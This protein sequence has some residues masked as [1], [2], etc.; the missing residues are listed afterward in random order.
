MGPSGSSTKREVGVGVCRGLFVS[1]PLTGLPPPPR[2]MTGSPETGRDRRV[3]DKVVV[4][5]RLNVRRS[6]D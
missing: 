2:S 5:S 6:D 1:G 3:R 4:V